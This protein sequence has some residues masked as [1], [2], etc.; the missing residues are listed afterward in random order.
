MKPIEPENDNDHT[1]PVKTPKQLLWV[2]LGAFFIP[3]VAIIALTYYVANVHRP[4]P[5]FNPHELV[6]KS[7]KIIEKVGKV[8]VIDETKP[9]KA[10]NEVYQ[11]QCITCH[12]K[13]TLGAPKFGDNQAWSARINKGYDSL[14]NSVYNGKNAMAAQRGGEFTDLELA[15]AMVFLVNSSG[16]KFP[17]P[18]LANKEKESTKPTS[19]APVK[20]SK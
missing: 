4:S 2:V 15:K 20:N 8:E 7:N 12:E 16:G 14:L 18:S 11:A 13:G 10:G 1:G 3:V 17:E 5:G 9:P 6:E 19:V